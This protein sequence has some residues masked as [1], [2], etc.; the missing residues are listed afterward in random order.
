MCGAFLLPYRHG[1]CRT[2]VVDRRM[3]D[4]GDIYAS[5]EQRLSDDA[6]CEEVL[7]KVLLHRSCL[8]RKLCQPSAYGCNP[9]KDRDV[10]LMVDSSDDKVWLT[11]FST[12]LAHWQENCRAGQPG[13]K[14]KA[15]C[16]QKTDPV[17]EAVYSMF[18][19]ED[20]ASQL[21]YHIKGAAAIEAAYNDL[22]SV[23]K[24]LQ[25]LHKQT[26]AAH[27]QTASNTASQASSDS[28][29]RQ[30]E[31]NAAIEKIQAVLPFLEAELLDAAH[32]DPSRLL[33]PVVMLP[34][35]Q[36]RL[37]DE[38][39]QHAE[40]TAQKAFDDLLQ[41]EASVSARAAAKGAAKQAR[42]LRQKAKRTPVIAQQAAHPLE[43]AQLMSNVAS[44]AY[45]EAPSAASTA[46][47]TVAPTTAP[48]TAEPI[49][50]PA[51]EQDA[52]AKAKHGT[53]ALPK[54]TQ[55]SIQN[56]AD[57]TVTVSICKSDQPPVPCTDSM[58]TCCSQPA[59]V[60]CAHQPAW[61]STSCTSAKPQTL[62]EQTRSLFLDGQ[63]PAAAKV[64][65][66]N[67]LFCCPIT[68]VLLVEPVIAADGHT[69]EKSAMEH[70][71]G[72]HVTSPV[73]G[74]KL[75][76]ARLVPNRVLRS[77]IANSAQ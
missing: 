33:V 45:A 29:R 76:H 47:P 34:L 49:A 73:T 71:L 23:L 67:K 37:S 10:C 32:D 48:T 8:V 63:R 25:A 3:V 30:Q 69:Y 60:P 72:Q 57:A 46:A 41:D 52:S 4:E 6:L 19:P 11:N 39:A 51:S 22:E 24:E 59:R 31:R 64:P 44:Q 70:W 36:E 2:Q 15:E 74:A 61:A 53:A 65:A 27:E 43:S 16:V 66:A 50:A 1:V 58:L 68:K 12:N 21:Q 13:V 55:I 75:M 17:L 28:F 56:A 18:S 40:R 26:N 9:D 20:I 35:I 14:P 38:A 54:C 5:E 42:K 62:T 7:D 77:I